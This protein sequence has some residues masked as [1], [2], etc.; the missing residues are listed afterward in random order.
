MEEVRL[1]LPQLIDHALFERHVKR[2]TFTAKF[3]GRVAALLQTLSL[4][5]Y[6]IAR[7][8]ILHLVVVLVFRADEAAV[9]GQLLILELFLLQHKVRGMEKTPTG[10]V[11]QVHVDLLNALEFFHDRAVDAHHIT[12]FLRDGEILEALGMECAKDV[13][14][15]PG[16]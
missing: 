12:D 7:V 10:V 13:L 5:L 9:D 8:I 4:G 11:V 6:L 2:I 16:T 3:V 1:P 15:F 14:D